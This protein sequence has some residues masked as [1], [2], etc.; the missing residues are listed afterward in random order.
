MPAI[1][2]INPSEVGIRVTVDHSWAC[3]EA[4]AAGR[5]CVAEETVHLMTAGSNR[6]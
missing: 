2:F 4:E 5:E 6:G 1:I 3:G